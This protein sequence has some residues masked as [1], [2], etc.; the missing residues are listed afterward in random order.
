MEVD[1]FEKLGSKTREPLLMSKSDQISDDLS[2]ILCSF[3]K[4]KVRFCVFNV[5]YTQ[6]GC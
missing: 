5:V 6:F 3:V 2:K 4:D 1:D